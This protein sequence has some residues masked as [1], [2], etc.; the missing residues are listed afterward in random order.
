MIRVDEDALICDLAETYHIYDYRSLPVALVAT[1]SCGLGEN[2]RIKRKLSGEP[3]PLDSQLLAIIADCL[4]W[5]K[6]A[7]TEDGAKN[8]NAPT[9]FYNAL[10]GY[11][12]KTKQKDP[13][14]VVFDSSDDLLA[15]L[16]RIRKERGA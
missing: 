15:E 4:T 10:M 11:E 3:V 5:L 8:R 12:Q 7:K 16:E 13:D 2:S 1:F 9:S 6:W 14:V